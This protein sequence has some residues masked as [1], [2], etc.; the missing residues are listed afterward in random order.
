MNRGFDLKKI[1]DVRRTLW[2]DDLLKKDA[3]SYGGKG[4]AED[5]GD[6]VFPRKG[7]V[8]SDCFQGF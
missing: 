5:F 3:R 4:T 7:L 8:K 1:G 6:V 2:L